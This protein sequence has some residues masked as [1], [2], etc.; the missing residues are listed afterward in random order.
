MEE[1]SLSE[2][3]VGDKNT[4]D[5]ARED[6]A[7][8]TPQR[9]REREEEKENDSCHRGS[10]VNDD[11]ST[12]T[13]LPCLSLSR[14]RKLVTTELAARWVFGVCAGNGRPGQRGWGRE[15]SFVSGAPR[16]LQARPNR[17]Q[18]TP[19]VGMRPR[20]TQWSEALRVEDSREGEKRH[21]VQTRAERKGK[22]G[23]ERKKIGKRALEYAAVDDRWAKGN[24]ECR[25]TIHRSEKVVHTAVV[26][27]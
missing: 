12:L 21:E 5:S 6:D 24:E 20:A 22:R 7:L 14:T 4:G 15:R 8:S 13:S 10:A 2:G 1:K 19:R 16:G 26:A 17:T 18:R 11:K 9:T 27:H 3:W 23:K 25:V